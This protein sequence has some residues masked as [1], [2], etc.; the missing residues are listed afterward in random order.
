MSV[1]LQ[2]VLHG[3]ALYSA[4]VCERSCTAVDERR[5]NAAVQ[6]A[7]EETSAG[8][9]KGPDRGTK[10]TIEPLSSASAYCG[11]TVL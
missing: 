1:L 5:L 8:M 4:A 7:E 9:V 3:T 2:V 6:P 11:I 10:I